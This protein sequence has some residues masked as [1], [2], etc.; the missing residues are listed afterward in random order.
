M[1]GSTTTEPVD[2]T[3]NAAE[4]TV[5]HVTHWKAG[6]QWVNRILHHL[7]YE[8]LLFVQRDQFAGTPIQ[9]GKVYPTLYVT[10]DEFYGNV[11]PAH[12]RRFVIIRD[13]R[14]TLVSFY[15]SLKFS[16]PDAGP[17]LAEIRGELGGRGVEA[18]L[19]FTMDAAL[20]WCASIQESW[21]RSG[22]PV[23]RYEELLE[24]D[25]AMFER[26]LVRHCE[27]RV[28]PDRLRE[29][30]VATR[31]ENWTGGR[32]RGQEN[33]LSHERKG[34][35]GDW[36][37]YFSSRIKREFKERYGDLLVLTGYEKDSDW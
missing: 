11:I 23:V 14:D 32:R 19:L 31:F 37:T 24:N 21:V 15:F 36:R 4:P 18:G 12:H 30:V 5:F 17:R 25:L 16:H 28:S 35:A 33:V 7:A 3:P 8:R 20:P 6:S 22:E 27:L 2:R 13:L 9:H 1:T 34:I 29:A 26:V 10:L